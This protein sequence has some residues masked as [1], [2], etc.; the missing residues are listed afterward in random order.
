MKYVHCAYM[1]MYRYVYRAPQLIKFNIPLH[2]IFLYRNRNE[3]N[4]CIPH[5]Q[6]LL[7]SSF[8]VVFPL[9][10]LVN[11]N[12]TGRKQPTN[13]KKRTSWNPPPPL[14][15]TIKI[16]ASTTLHR[17][18]NVLG[19]ALYRWDQIEFSAVRYGERPN[20]GHWKPWYRRC[21]VFLLC[22]PKLS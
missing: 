12:N 5:G 16:F 7:S 20:R 11:W 18:H 6:A 10:E 2:Y 1:Y 4:P 17:L 3:T 22:H 13:R 21:S 14:Q 9:Q 15:L 8:P 19:K